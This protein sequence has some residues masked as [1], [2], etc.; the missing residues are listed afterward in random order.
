MT[1]QAIADEW[2]TVEGSVRFIAAGGD[3]VEP[4]RDERLVHAAIL[5][6]VRDGRIPPD[7]LKASARRIARVKAWLAGQGQANPAWL[8][9]AE[10]R[11]LAATIARDAITLVRDATQALP[12]PR[13]SRVAVVECVYQARTSAVAEV[14]RPRFG[15]VTGVVVNAQQPTS[16]E[17]D[18]AVAVANGASVVVYATRS[19]PDYP[20]QVRLAA[21]L[22][23]TG[24]PVVAVALAE[25]YDAGAYPGVPT[26]LATYG[27]EQV[28]LN[29]LGAALAGE[30]PLRGKLPVTI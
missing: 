16:A 18:A 28:V 12:L 27:A 21:T 14:L 11:T 30:Q 19:A 5:A 24:K 2:G 22:L 10:H 23:G 17:I 15:A 1:M 20:G 8:G 9:A 29:A 7:Q 26:A 13:A 3:L 25:P 4:L 6:A